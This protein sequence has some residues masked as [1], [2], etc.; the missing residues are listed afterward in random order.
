M[1][2]A[3]A[4]AY[5]REFGGAGRRPQPG[6]GAEPPGQ[7]VRVAKPAWSWKLF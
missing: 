1:A 3:G 5:M 4:R 6:P 2:S 7:G